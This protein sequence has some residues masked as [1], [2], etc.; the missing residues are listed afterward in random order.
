MLLLWSKNI[1]GKS[2]T[3]KSRNYGKAQFPMKK[4]CN[5][6]AQ[7]DYTKSCI[8]HF[9]HTVLALVKSASEAWKKEFAFFLKSQTNKQNQHPT[10]THHSFGHF[11]RI[12]LWAEDLHRKP[13]K[14]G[15]QPQPTT[16]D[17]K[18]Y[19]QALLC[20]K[21]WKRPGMPG[22]L[23][24]PCGLSPQPRLLGPAPWSGARPKTPPKAR[25]GH[26]TPSLRNSLAQNPNSHG[27]E[28]T[29]SKDG[30][31]WSEPRAPHTPWASGA[32][33][34]TGTVT[35]RQDRDTRWKEGHWG[36][37]AG[38]EPPPGARLEPPRPGQGTGNWG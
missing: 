25:N 22:V 30:V 3:R 4:V 1:S 15:L 38:L 27:T 35:H 23:G 2:L 20:M 34:G 17:K 28:H 11:L 18:R 29:L 33:T 32:W 19:L 16:K 7:F 13:K 5:S 6:S 9:F 12:K 26:R 24:Q 31:T 8:L 21:T 14:D 36:L 10:I 37:G